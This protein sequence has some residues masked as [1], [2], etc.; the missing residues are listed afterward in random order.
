MW[1]SQRFVLKI[2]YVGL[3]LLIH[4]LYKKL[5]QLLR[6]P[7]SHNALTTL[8][9]ICNLRDD[10]KALGKS[11]EK[12][13]YRALW[14]HKNH[15]WTLNRNV[16]STAG[17]EYTKSVGTGLERY[18]RD[19]DYRFL[20]YRVTDLF[21][22][23]LKSNI[24]NLKKQEPVPLQRRFFRENRSYPD[25]QGLEEARY[26]SVVR[27]RLRK[28]VLYLE[29]VKANSK[30]IEAAALL[31]HEIVEYANDGKVG[32]AA[33]LQWKTMVEDTHSKH[34]KFKNCVVVCD[35]SPFVA[36]LYSDVFVA[37]AVLVSQLSEEPWKGKEKG[38]G[39][40]VPQ[41]VFWELEAW[42]TP[43]VPCRGPGV[44]TLGGFSNKLF[45]LF[46]DNNGELGRHHVMEATISGKEYQNL[47]VVH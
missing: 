1:G 27:D 13:L 25:N 31:P 38:Y 33:E 14:L 3:F 8:K 10:S 28:E 44:A 47:V 16:T 21:A 24:Q 40:A 2:I 41:I 43:V 35:V 39:D 32:K 45:K 7:W 36:K 18:E 4:R 23:Y 42:G 9:F 17:G 22:D 5:D 19:L 12:A 11:D 6:L 30:N 34:G 37:L 29:E 26:S 20:H 46:L 15:P